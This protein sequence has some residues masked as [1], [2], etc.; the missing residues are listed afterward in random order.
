VAA[1]NRTIGIRHCDVDVDVGS[2]KAQR[3]LQFQDF[4]VSI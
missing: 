2:T 3:A 4:Q 1:Q